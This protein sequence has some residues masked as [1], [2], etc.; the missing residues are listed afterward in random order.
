MNNFDYSIEY[1]TA[2]HKTPKSYDKYNRKEKEGKHK[3]T[4]ILHVNSM[5]EFSL[6]IAMKYSCAITRTTL[7]FIR[8]YYIYVWCLGYRKANK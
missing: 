1:E 4:G 7:Y 5:L 6:P 2:Y 3:S 8:T